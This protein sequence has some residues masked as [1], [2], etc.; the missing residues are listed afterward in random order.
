MKLAKIGLT[1]ILSLVLMALISPALQASA[2]S[3]DVDLEAT[4]PLTISDVS[5]S[6]IG[7]YGATIS[8]NTNGDA[9]SQVFYDTTWHNTTAEYAYDTTEDTD[10]V[11]EHSVPLTGLSSGTTYHYRVRSAIP[12]TEFI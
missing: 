3:D 11:T 10:L 12:D 5:A 4:V 2:E 8:W 9:T 1:I 7:Y 6:S